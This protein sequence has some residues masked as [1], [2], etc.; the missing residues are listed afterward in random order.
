MTTQL[1]HLPPEILLQI[2]DSL[3]ITPLVRFAQTSKYARNL[4]YSNV[5]DLSLAIYPSHRNSWHNKLFAAGHKPK[6]ALNAAIQ[7][8][9]AWEFD[10]S[11]LIKFHDKVIASIVTRHAC[12]LQKVDLTVWRMS[13]PM[14]KAISQLPALRELGVSI[15]SLQAIPRAYMNMQREEECAAWSQLASN[16]AFMGSVNTLIIKNAEINTTQLSDL[17]NG[18]ERWKDLRLSRCNMLTS[19]IW[20][21]TRLRSLHHLSLTDCVNVHVKEAAVDTISKM[22]RLQVRQLHSKHCHCSSRG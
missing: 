22:N 15:E 12:A 17:T 18:A 21:S 16:P 19:E 6:H 3:P 9:R 5:Q 2:L 11:T 20:S 7:I 4:A 10:Y 13:K 8:P 1:F 14:A